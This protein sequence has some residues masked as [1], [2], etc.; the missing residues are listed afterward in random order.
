VHP[1]DPLTGRRHALHELESGVSDGRDDT[2]APP[3]L[4]R[5]VAEHLGHQPDR[6]VEGRT[7]RRD[8]ARDTQREP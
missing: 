3:R 6:L 2:Q 4:R 5:A 1:H 7:G 8:L